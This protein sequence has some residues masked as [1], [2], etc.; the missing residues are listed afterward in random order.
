MR[1]DIPNLPWRSK[2]DPAD[3]SPRSCLRVYTNISRPDKMSATGDDSTTDF[4]PDANLLQRFSNAD[5]RSAT[6]H[7]LVP[8][9]S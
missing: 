5:L 1:N 4:A 3:V 6:S 2:S 8:Q 7:D 9:S